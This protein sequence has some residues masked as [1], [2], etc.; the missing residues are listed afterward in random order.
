MAQTGRLR[1]WR[2]RGRLTHYYLH[3]TPGGETEVELERM[4][5]EWSCP[6]TIRQDNVR[7]PMKIVLVGLLVLISIVVVVTLVGFSLPANHV[8]KTK[9]SLSATPEE[10]WSVITDIEKFPAWRSDVKSVK[11][12]PDSAG[13]PSWVE[14]GS[15]GKISYRH[16][17]SV[18][19]TKLR[20][21]LTD[22]SL[23]FGGTWTYDITPTLA[24]SDVTITEKGIVR[25][26]IFRFMS[27]FV[28]GHYNTQETYMR[29]L[30]KKFNQAV[31]P[32]RL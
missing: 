10:V 1:F 6:P 18:R 23:P 26:P 14:D 28:F 9:T 19:P 15:N 22:D 21:L 5:F 31:T 29:D 3:A 4:S 17:E 12:A 24:G 16:Q 30:G 25:N 20:V 8:A 2:G 27:R 11:I 32:V 13:N 7:K